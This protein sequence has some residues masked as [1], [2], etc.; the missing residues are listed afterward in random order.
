MAK[1]LKTIG[2]VLGIFILLF[3]VIV[4]GFVSFV[5]PNRF[6]PLITNQVKKYSGRELS[7][8]GDLSWQVFPTLGVKA[9]H[10]SLYNP[11]GFK[12]KTFAEIESATVS[13]KV[14]PLLRGKVQSQGMTIKGLKLYLIK[15]ADGKV[16][17]QS[18]PSPTEIPANTKKEVDY[19]TAKQAAFGG[20]AVSTIDISNAMISFVDEQTK[21]TFTVDHFNLQVKDIN[22]V[23]PFSLNSSFNF[24][25]NESQAASFKIQTKISLSVEKQLVA[26]NDFNVNAKLNNKGHDYDA[27]VSAQILTNLEKE[28]LQIDDLTGSIENLTLKGKVNIT[29][30][31][32]EPMA[33]GQFE[34][35]PLDLRAFLKK[36]GM[37]VDHL[38][39]VRD[40]TGRFNF[41]MGKTLKSLKA[42]GN[43]KLNEL[44]TDKIYVSDI[45]VKT[46]LQNGILQLAP[47]TGKFY[48][49]MIDGQMKVDFLS[50]LP[51]ISLQAKL[52]NVQAEP[53]LQNL[54]PQQK[55][56][57]SGVGN[58]DLNLTSAGNNSDAL[59]SNL[60]GNVALQFNNGILKGIDINY[61]IDSA[62]ALANKQPVSTTDTEQT[63]FGTLTASANIQKGIVSNKD[64]YLNAPRFE[65]RGNGTINLVSQQIHYQLQ[66]MIKKDDPSR[67]DNLSNLY[68]YGV[69]LAI[70]GN[71][72]NPAIRL[73]M[74]V[75]MKE[76]AEQQLKK[77]KEQ[78][79]EKI[80]DKIKEH[81]P[82]E[83]KDKIP[84]N[85]GKLLNNILGQ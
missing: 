17:W 68:G 85:A 5:S 82:D 78:V 52:N 51:Q 38:K 19:S 36:I 81:L 42:E 61:F 63:P 32:K 18:V 41:T 58:V 39:N 67:R 73:D 1:I 56:K 71:L 47:F 10:F 76:I 50:T 79:Q 8:D 4:I 21:K 27:K 43:F 29:Q 55:L 60:N 24:K 6:K 26:L 30:F 23:K 28:T 54:K 65:T 53:L 66:I 13:V 12:Q 44:Q 33:S 16:N 70:I 84:E 2:I 57:I 40:L 75:L 15:N 11:E 74:E 48:Q 37:D 7:I 80:Q 62:I 9:G 45:N 83:L 22:L 35:E 49:G 20:L 64:L 31:P 25:N 34:V 77:A 3:V 59:I 72:N 46:N 69:P 14:I